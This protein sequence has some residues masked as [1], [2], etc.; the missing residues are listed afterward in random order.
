MTKIT[1]NPITSLIDEHFTIEK[2]HNHQH[3]HNIMYYQTF[4]YDLI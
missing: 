1:F 4:I 3:N 2:D